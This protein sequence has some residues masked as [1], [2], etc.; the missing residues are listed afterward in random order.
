MSMGRK[1]Y[2]RSLEMLCFL[3]RC[4]IVVSSYL[5]ELCREQ[6]VSVPLNFSKRRNHVKTTKLRHFARHNHKQNKPDLQMNHKEDMGQ[7]QTSHSIQW[8]MSVTKLILVILGLL[9]GIAFFFSDDYMIKYDSLRGLKSNEQIWEALDEKPKFIEIDG[10][11]NRT[12][13]I[14]GSLELLLNWL[15]ELEECRE[16]YL[17]NA[18]GSLKWPRRAQKVQCVIDAL[19]DTVRGVESG[20]YPNDAKLIRF[21]DAILHLRA[22]MKIQIR[23][24]RLEKD[25]ILLLKQQ[26]ERCR[27]ELYE[28]QERKELRDEHGLILTEHEQR[29]SLIEHHQA[30]DYRKKSEKK[31]AFLERMKRSAH[32]E[33]MAMEIED[34]SKTD[35]G[36]QCYCIAL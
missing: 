10:R 18:G 25:T 24:L 27:Q 33:K 21:D 20:N 16:T 3:S 4:S 22:C 23:R 11:L 7:N 17:V 32:R 12:Y 31:V 34:E 6:V 8:S 19:V 13:S 14:H 1:G 35:R 28:N 5:D 9:S 29:E 26:N 15:R 2:H 30:K 36:C